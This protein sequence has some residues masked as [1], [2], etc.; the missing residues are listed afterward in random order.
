MEFSDEM[1]RYRVTLYGSSYTRERVK[2]RLARLFRKRSLT[3]TIDGEGRRHVV[4]RNGTEIRYADI[5]HSGYF[6]EP[7]AEMDVRSTEDYFD[8]SS[9]ALDDYSSRN[10]LHLRVSAERLDEE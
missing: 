4:L 3:D 8:R 5:P 9:D 10:K 7:F 6:N 2:T 1:R